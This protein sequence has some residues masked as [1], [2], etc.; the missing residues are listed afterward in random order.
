MKKSEK[1]ARSA[2]LAREAREACASDDEP[3]ANDTSER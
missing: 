2:D 1:F 3:N